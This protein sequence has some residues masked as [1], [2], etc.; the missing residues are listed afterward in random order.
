MR[1]IIKN[2]GA[3]FVCMLLVFTFTVSAFA[4]IDCDGWANYY[5]WE[6]VESRKLFGADDHSAC[7][8]ISAFARV[9]F[10]EE[11]R[12][13]YLALCL[14]NDCETTDDMSNSI[15]LRF[16]NSPEIVL[17]SDG[18]AEYDKDLF[19]VKFGYLA[20]SWGGGCY[21]VDF[22]LK[23]T[24]Y[25][26]TLIMTLE[27]EDYEG[28]ASQAY[29][30][31]IKSEE[32]LEAESRSEAESKKEA[33]KESKKNAKTTKSKTTKAKKAKTTKTETTTEHITEVI[34]EDYEKFM[35]NQNNNTRSILVIGVVCAVLSV[36]AM[37]FSFTLKSKKDRK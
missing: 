23:E 14:E 4:E 13:V 24:D 27:I 7:V 21:E 31:I 12:R 30:L 36:V 28:N 19:D 2:T 37:G 5:E 17:Y 10:E 22:L 1:K 35:E 32:L 6:D 20:D 34:T 16:N 15:K 33:E 8:Y 11:K 9:K 18:R 26:E 25:S 29:D 3:F